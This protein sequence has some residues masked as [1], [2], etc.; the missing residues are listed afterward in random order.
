[1]NL[2]A[3][4]AQ[5]IE[6]FL[7]ELNI[8]YV[9]YPKRITLPCPIHK[10][11]NEEGC[12]IYYNAEYPYWKCFTHNCHDDGKGMLKFI[13]GVLNLSTRE[14]I[15][16]I[17]QR[18][19]KTEYVNDDRYSF[20]YE[21]KEFNSEKNRQI[22]SRQ[23]FLSKVTCPSRYFVERGFDKDILV[24]YDCGTWNVTRETVI[25]VYDE[26][27]NFVIGYIERSENKKCCLCDMYHNF[28]KPCPTTKEE[29]A[30]SNKWK[31]SFAF[32]SDQSMYNLWFARDHIINSKTVVLV[33]G[34]G[35]IWS[36]EKAGIRNG[37][38]LFGVELKNGQ[39]KI[40]D[41]LGVQNIVLFLD[42]DEAGQ[43]AS[44][45][46][47]TKFGRYYNFYRLNSKY[48]PGDS[49]PEYISEQFSL[50]GV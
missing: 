47:E 19:G 44:N 25:P 17:E 6:P 38:G 11:D 8:D 40:L 33:E 28:S 21:N 18:I 1:M 46:I 12:S 14:T 41:D 4:I 26:N 3:K 31:N 30:K 22:M 27:Y 49:S 24:K 42:P 15:S 16:W 48:D 5:N 29:K 43:E 9:K 50:L 32:Y 23:E 35:D 37:L 45:K 2:N 20:I 39:R 36:L 7:K 34:Q 13:S 10:G